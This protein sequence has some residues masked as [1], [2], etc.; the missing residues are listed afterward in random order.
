M[1]KTKTVQVTVFYCDVCGSECGS[2]M[3][4]LTMKGQEFH[5]CSAWDEQKGTCRERLDEVAD[6]ATKDIAP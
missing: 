6:A 1:K 4:T 5:A 2:S 3:T